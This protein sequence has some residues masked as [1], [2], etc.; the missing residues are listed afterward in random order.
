MNGLLFCE[1]GQNK[2][3]FVLLVCPVCIFINNVTKFTCKRKSNKV[4]KQNNLS[5]KNRSRSIESKAKV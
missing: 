1:N 2:T 3:K 5:V 4:Q